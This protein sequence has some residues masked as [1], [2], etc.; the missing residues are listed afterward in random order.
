MSHEPLTMDN[1]LINELFNSK[2]QIKATKWQSDEVL[3]FQDSKIR[4]FQVQDSKIRR[5]PNFTASNVHNSEFPNSFWK[6]LDH[7]FSNMFH[8]PSLISQHVIFQHVIK[9]Y[10]KRSWNTQ[11]PIHFP[12]RDVEILPNIMFLNNDLGSSGISWNRF[13]QKIMEP[14]SSN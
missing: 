10:F 1:R 13:L 5:F 11:F 12:T 4:R 2:F 7:A 14:E 9:L 6:I 8:A 3:E